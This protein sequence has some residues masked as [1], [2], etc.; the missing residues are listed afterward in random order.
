MQIQQENFFLKAIYFIPSITPVCV[1]DI[2]CMMSG[3]WCWRL[4]AGGPGVY[5]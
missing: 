5:S 4:G 3:K 2:Y 1:T